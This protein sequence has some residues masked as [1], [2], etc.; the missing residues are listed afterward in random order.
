ML[1]MFRLLD[2]EIDTKTDAELLRK[3]RE[4]RDANPDEH[5][6]I[7]EELSSRRRGTWNTAKLRY[8]MNR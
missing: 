4:E 8:E 3:A 5:E 7:L 1:P 6:Q 2:S